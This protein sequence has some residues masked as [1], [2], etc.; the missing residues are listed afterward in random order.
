MR[1]NLA[2]HCALMAVMLFLA[3]ASVAPAQIV[4]N[5]KTITMEA[6]EKDC[7]CVP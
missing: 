2:C 5:K 6:A 1:R 4:F 3:L 7:E